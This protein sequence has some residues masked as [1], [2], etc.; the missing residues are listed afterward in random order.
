[1]PRSCACAVVCVRVRVCARARGEC[2]CVCVVSACTDLGNIK[3]L[4]ELGPNVGA[5]AVA[6]CQTQ[7]AGHTQTKAD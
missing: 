5:E 7:P 3:A 2:V 6:D 1:V 4:L